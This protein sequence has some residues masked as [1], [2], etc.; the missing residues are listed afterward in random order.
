MAVRFPKNKAFV[1]C[2]GGCKNKSCSSGCIA[3]GKCSDICRFGAIH[4]SA[5]GVAL[6]DE[7]RC[8]GCGACVR[9]CPQHVIK[10]YSEASF[11]RI[12]CSNHLK[13]VDARKACDNSCIACGLC[14]RVCTSSAISLVDNLAVIDEEL[15]LSCG[16]CAVKC[17]RH[18]I[19]DMRGI[20]TE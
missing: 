15:C 5:N 6:V 4:I 14:T 18:V 3:C 7:E 13:G 8:I 17:P 16:M 9:S 1:E 11:I 2:N 10:L 19:K 12:R 20:L